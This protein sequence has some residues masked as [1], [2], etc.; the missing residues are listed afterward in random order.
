MDKVL[1][2]ARRCHAASACVKPCD[3]RKAAELLHGSDVIVCGVIGFPHGNSTIKVKVFETEQA[4]NDGAVEIDM[5]VNIGKAKQLSNMRT[6]SS[7]EATRL[8]PP[9]LHTLEQALEYIADD[10][11]V[12]VTH[13]FIRMRK[14]VLTENDRKKA[15]R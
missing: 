4:M 10:E 11:L 3:I 13:N 5:V 7:D 12:E 6:S 9:R 8:T 14:R 15:N 1:E 2:I